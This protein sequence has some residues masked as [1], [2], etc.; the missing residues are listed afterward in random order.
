MLPAVNNCLHCHCPV[1]KLSQC[2]IVTDGIRVL[3]CTSTCFLHQTY[4][5]KAVE[6][7]I[8]YTKLHTTIFFVSFSIFA[9]NFEDPIIRVIKKLATTKTSY[10]DCCISS[11]SHQRTWSLSVTCTLRCQDG[12]PMFSAH[13]VA[14]HQVQCMIVLRIHIAAYVPVNSA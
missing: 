13:T 4:A 2:S 8:N 3:L 11:L 1:T 14:M 7:I 9:R 12:F 6:D 5:V 10:R